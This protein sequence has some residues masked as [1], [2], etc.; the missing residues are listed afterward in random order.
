ME[1]PEVDKQ[2]QEILQKDTA[3]P[4]SM[5][6]FAIDAAKS[7]EGLI[8]QGQKEEKE[9]EERIRADDNPLR[10][11]AYNKALETGMSYKDAESA[12]LFGEFSP[13]GAVTMGIDA[14]QAAKEGDYLEAGLSGAGALATAVGAGAVAKPAVKGAIKQLSRLEVEPNTLGSN[15]GNIRLKPAVLEKRKDVDQKLGTLEAAGVTEEDILQ[16]RKPQSEG[17]SATTP[18]F[19]KALKGRDQKLM[20][21]ALEVQQ[22]KAS[23]E[24]YRKLADELRPIRKMQAVPEPATYKEMI[25]ALSESKRTKGIVGL[26]TNIP[27]G[28]LVDVRLDIPA[29]TDYDTWIPT[30]TGG[31]ADAKKLLKENASPTV[32][33]PTVHLKNVSFIQP[34][35]IKA[36]D[37]AKNV[38]TGPKHLEESLGMKKAKAEMQGNKHPFATMT[39]EF[40]NTTDDAAYKQAQKFFNDDEWTQIGYD[41][42]KRGYFYSRETGD[43]VLSAEEVIQVGGLVLAKKAKI[44]KAE[45]FK[46]NRG[47]AVKKFNK[48]GDTMEDQMNF[49]FMNEGGVLADDGVERDPVSGNE[50]PSGSMAE[51]VRDDIPAM[52]SEGEYVVPADVVRYH[53]IQKFEDLRNEAKVGLQR[54]EAD[55]RI[56]GQPVEEQDELPFSI[57]ELEVTEAYR[58]GIMGF[59]EGGDA[60]SYE[61]AFGQPYTPGQRYGTMGTAQLGFQLRNFT[62][63]K[64]GKTVT[65]PFFNGKPM[66]YIPP[67]FTASDVVGSGGGTFDPAAD[68]RD[69]QEREAELARS[70]G[71]GM[72]DRAFEA[73]RR[74][75]SDVETQPTDFKDFTAEDWQRYNSQQR[76][77]LTSVTRKIPIL[78]YFQGLNEKAARDFAIQATTTGKN[79]ETGEAL[80]KEEIDVLNKVATTPL[81]KSLLESLQD[82]IDQ[83]QPDFLELEQDRTISADPNMLP[84]AT[85]DT[86]PSAFEDAAQQAVTDAIQFTPI[87]VTDDNIGDTQTVSQQAKSIIASSV[88]ASDR[89][90]NDFG[91]AYANSPELWQKVSQT[92][93][94]ASK[95][96]FLMSEVG[97]T[98]AQGNSLGNTYGEIINNLEKSYN[99]NY[100]ENTGLFMPYRVETQQDGA[101]PFLT[102]GVGHKLPPNAD[103]NKGYTKNEILNFL[104]EDLNIARKNAERVVQEYGGNLNLLDVG[105]QVILTN[106]AAQTG[107]GKYSNIKDVLAGRMDKSELGGLAGFQ[108]AVEAAISGDWARFKTEVM[109]SKLGRE[110]ATDRYTQLT[111][112]YLD[113]NSDKNIL[114]KEVIDDPNS[115]KRAG[116]ARPTFE[117]PQTLGVTRDQISGVT[118]TEVLPETRSQIATR[119]DINNLVEQ[120][121]DAAENMDDSEFRNSLRNVDLENMTT[122]EKF[123]PTFSAMDLPAQP[124]F[125]PK[126]VMDYGFGTAGSPDVTPTV[127]QQEFKLFDMSRFTTSVDRAL[128]A[129]GFKDRVSRPLDSSVT[130]LPVNLPSGFDFNRTQLTQVPREAGKSLA[131]QTREALIR[132]APDQIAFED[133]PVTP[134]GPAQITAGGAKGTLPQVDTTTPFQDVAPLG[135]RKVTDARQFLDTRS[136]AQQAVQDALSFAPKTRAKTKPK[137]TE[138]KVSQSEYKKRVKE[139][140]GKEYDKARKDA[141]EARDS[142]LRQ[143]GSVQEAFD[144]AQ[145]AFTGFTPS[146]EFVGPTDPGTAAMDRFSTSQGLG[147]KEGGLASKPKKTKP[148]KRNTKKGL[149]GRMAT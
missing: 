10:K 113:I 34:E 4:E 81:N 41:P 79:P 140:T 112:E 145:T 30:I 75:M 8:A 109:N 65:I 135:E 43:P 98:D 38:A 123:T 66:Q 126:F 32:Y 94:N 3:V 51:E 35:D 131:E 49:A 93:F 46:F 111:N 5:K 129:I 28:T 119:A 69:R 138:E 74:A 31:S 80:T 29:Y 105:P 95:L 14:Y 73:A 96:E 18:A 132:T 141:D 50:V 133:K 57:E 17:G 116:I 107:G 2:T 52:L 143:G 122:K 1:T 40:L 71:R 110:Q 85:A 13:V 77:I 83:Q 115:V 23:I 63:P 53:G 91:V 70:T 39:G 36:Q 148:K 144:A 137:A 54:M 106:I 68:E 45:D 136:A 117:R 7:R 124:D 62:N 88:N 127:P 134:K 20:D 108:N 87:D 26:Q 114:Q 22:G 97:M 90:V 99:I 67:D 25:G 15:L 146:G 33:S 101:E 56:G 92:A 125:Q 19:R 64:T 47:G 12:V 149:G 104:N 100:D 102:V 120:N 89:E 86:D 147:F 11:A 6:G 121:L 42:T 48:G 78:G 139:A 37:F 82:V 142:V 55:G 130:Q 44:G 60:G 24:D 21:K 58:G 84:S 59:Q 9:A 72:S 118:S 128:E 61:E 27:E 103:P 16:F 76:G